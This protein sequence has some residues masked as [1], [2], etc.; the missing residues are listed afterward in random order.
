[1]SFGFEFFEIK[2]TIKHAYF[3][4]TACLGLAV[5]FISLQFASSKHLKLFDTISNVCYSIALATPPIFLLF[6]ALTV[7]GSLVGSLITQIPPSVLSATA[8]FL[9]GFFG[10]NLI[11]LLSQTIKNKFNEEK[12]TKE[13]DEELELLARAEK[14]FSVG[15]YDMAVNESGRVVEAF[16]RRFLSD[17]KAPTG[18]N[19]YELVQIAG[20]MDI[21]SPQDIDLLNVVRKARNKAIHEGGTTMET[22]Q[23]I[24]KLSRL[25][26]TKM[27]F[28]LNQHK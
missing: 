16:L 6:W 12:I 20:E 1:G 24:M 3:F 4:L 22:A 14:A 5:Y 18:Q 13:K 21:L 23:H 26:V 11:K 9:S 25:F 10:K 17:V 15:I 2:L 28:V 19:F 8:A 27:L 7:M